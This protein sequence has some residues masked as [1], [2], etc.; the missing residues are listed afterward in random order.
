MRRETP[1][2]A[3]LAQLMILLLLTGLASV[4]A[5][6]QTVNGAFHGTVTDTSGAV[7]P[8]AKVVVKNLTNGQVRQALTNSV[9][10]YTITQL[11][12]GRY[13]VT[14]SKAGFATVEQA[15]VELLVNQD[16][17]ANYTLRLGQVTQ[18]V[19]VTAAPP[20]LN[21]AS[22]TIGQVIGSRQ[23]VDLPLNGRQFTQLVLLTPGASPKESGQQSAFTIPI[24]GGG[25]SPSVNGERG[26]ENNFTLDG[27]LNNAIFT[28]VWAIS[29]PPDAIQEF[30]VQSHITDAQ[31]SISSGANVN[32]A[33]KSGGNQIHGDAWEF[34]RNDKFDAANFFDNF[35]N[36]RK[37]PFRQNQYGVTIGGPVML[38]HYDGRQ[39][40]TYFFGYWE[41]FR[42]SQGFTLF[43]NVPTSSELGGDFSDLLTNQ[44]AVDPTTKQ[45]V[46]DALGR[47]VMVGQIYN[48]YS[49]RQ[50]PNGQLVRDP[51]PGNIVPS[52]MLNAQA[53][54]YLQA[55]YPKPNFGPGGNSFP[56]FA[57]S[58]S[59]VI[60][61][62]QFGVRI[63]HTFA[64]NDTLHGA[65]YYSQPSETFP[66]SLLTGANTSKNHARVISVG[67]THLFSPT[68]LASFH[69][70]YN[71]TDFGTTNIPGGVGLL[72][73]IN[74]AAFEPVRDNIP[75]VPQI[76]LAPRLGGTG[77]FAIPLGPIRSHEYSGDI[78][79]IH[80]SHTL[81][82]GFM[83]YHIHSFDDGW[84]A[85]VGFDQFPSSAIYGNNL[86]ASS[87]GDGLASMLLN[88]PS[89]IFGFVGNTAANDT[90][91]WQGYYLQDKWQASK[92]LNI[93]IGI[94]YDYVPPAHYKN[95]QVSGW[96]PECPGSVPANAPQSV[97]NQVVQ[98]CFLIPVPLVQAPPAPTPQ[99]PFPQTPPSWPFPNVRQTYFDPKYNGWQPRFG[100]AYSMTPKTVAR[101]AFAMFDDHNNTLVQESQDPRIAW[102]FGAGIS[103]GSLNRGVPSGVLSQ[104]S[105]FWNNLPPASSFLPPSNPSPN[106]AFAADPR[107]KIPYSM[108]YNFGLER[109]LTA[110]TTFSLNYVGSESRHLFIQP[111]YNA[112]LP[113]EMGPGPVA[114]RTPFPFLG[115]FPNDFN[116]GVSN[117]N[118]LEAKVEKRF[119]QGLTFLASY[120][121]S[122]CLS[123]QDEGQSGSIQNP[124]NWSADYGP[125]DFNLSHI[126]VFSY[127]Y[128]IPYGQGMHFGSHA[129]RAANAVLGGWQIS[130]ITTAESGP[131]FGVSV[132]FD[133]ANI[134]PS[135]E[136]QRA[137]RVPGV[138]L[139]PA[140]FQQNIFHWYNPAAFAIPPQFTFGTLGRNTL[141]GPKL[142]NFDFAL[143]KNFKFTESKSL[144]FRSE[145]FNIFNE[146]NFS[147]PGGGASQGFS[148]LGGEVN[149]AISSPN[150]MRILSAA[151]AR[152]VQFSLKL[153]W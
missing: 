99:N 54:A 83:F 132:G 129:G 43:N 149:N 89:N 117:Y 53:L 122:K 112:P 139:L 85:S 16:L 20:M 14:V 36:Q 90:T 78:Q 39:K 92:K 105:V 30:N 40:K 131:P 110:N 151:A 107:L 57:T 18:Q 61:S 76:G 130:G 41:G 25:I 23:V 31:F 97:I 152:E 134:N 44:Q 121:Y 11:P 37:P 119:S 153:I 103:F 133:N 26:Q 71:W 48:P 126:F 102:P 109:Q 50:A 7:I 45:P 118:A 136:T 15:S 75:I 22:A 116:V 32:V 81:S 86:N 148:T 12:P 106:I 137:D 150:F 127:A 5:L 70:G 80:G 120:T 60:S 113:S 66:T 52:N 100:F 68:V 135:S 124:Y 108:E 63:D 138:P 74:A 145:F 142:V 27:V 49:T 3:V 28:D 34:I 93:Q 94:R 104:N 2:K 143:F 33:T 111:M 19:Q 10:F 13:S 47:P 123:I 6:A 98:S 147:P 128:Q 91:T 24:G 69:F 140:G 9:G 101:G 114:P 29:P 72:N 8:G 51:F 115:Q 77:Q 56:N 58:S 55:W 125:C 46:F 42:S 17:E 1:P 95:N 59:Q 35:A 146:V 4:A 65:F 84:G 62:D 82:A 88:L 64:N 21:T 73:A 79:K 38:P 96:N 67:Y 144:Q 141:T 87:T